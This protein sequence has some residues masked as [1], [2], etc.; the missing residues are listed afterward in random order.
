MVRNPRAKTRIRLEEDIHALF[1]ASQ[2]H[3]QVVALVL[4]HLEQHLDR[5]LAVIALVVGAVE[6]V[7]LVNEQHAAH[8]LFH[9]LLGL[10]RGVADILAD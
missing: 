9:D 1:V 10:R 6:V 3:H 5:L 4:H 2:D 7:S 8:R